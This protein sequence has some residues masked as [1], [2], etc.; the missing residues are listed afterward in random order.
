MR[1]KSPS[2]P[3]GQ[4]VPS[5]TFKVESWPI[6]RPRPYTHNPRRVPQSAIEKVARS[7]AEFGFRQ[8]IVVDPQGVI[9]VGHTRLLAAKKLGHKTVPV[10]VAY[11]LTDEQVKAYRLADNRTAQETDWDPELLGLEL[12]DLRALGLD[13]DLTA[14]EADEIAQLAG[15]REGFCDADEIPA[16]PPEAATRP[17]D[18]VR[19]GDDH[20]L[21]CGDAG[22]QSDF[23]RLLG[24]EQVDL[25]HGD[26]PYGT[27]VEPRSAN[28]IAAVKAASGK[29]GNH[30]RFD[31]GRRQAKPTGRV[32]RAK[33][34]PLIG[35]DLPAAE[36]E[37]V[38]AS[39]FP[40]MARVLKPGG[41]FYLWGGYANFANYPPALAAAGL[42]FSQAIVWVKDH[43]VLGRKDFM[44]DHEW[45]YYGW[46]EGAAHRFYGPRNV[47]D[48]WHVKKVSSQAMVHLT[49][50]PVELA[51]RALRCSSK[52]GELVLDCFA[53]SGSTL[54]ACQQAGRRARLVEIDPLYCDVIIRRFELFA[55]TKAVLLERR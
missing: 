16:L 31:D 52:P 25:F 32:L 34:R 26:P 47:P 33:D 15:E 20:L 35:D 43:P 23:D 50:K 6:D 4:A 2:R 37:K 45:C 24:R 1:K 19:L 27:H 9:I 3:A 46:K 22:S 40:N 49:E 8:P 29:L 18:L 42:Y 13:L 55:G 39:W 17:G 38:L 54:I 44:G 36:Y 48:V 41:V 51:L 7:I 21:L 53:G 5:G 11:G 30:Q 14:F 10:H 28:A 12:A